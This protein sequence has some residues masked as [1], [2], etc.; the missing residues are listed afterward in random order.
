[1]NPRRDEPEPV[2]RRTF[3]HAGTRT[4][5]VLAV[6]RIDKPNGTG[7][8][9]QV[10]LRVGPGRPAGVQRLAVTTQHPTRHCARC[11]FGMRQRDLLALG[12]V[13]VD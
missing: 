13:R 8:W 2:A 11:D 10:S 5:A 3:R 4:L 1:L 7:G 12:Y 9:W 6:D